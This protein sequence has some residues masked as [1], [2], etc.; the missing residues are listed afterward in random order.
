ML[1]FLGENDPSITSSTARQFVARVLDIPAHEI[2]LNNKQALSLTQ[3]DTLEP[4]LERLR[5]GEPLAYVE[6]SVG[7]YKHEFKI[8]NRALIPRADSEVIVEM[9]CDYLASI[10]S[11]SLLDVGTGSGCLIISLLSELPAA[12]GV[13]VDIKKEALGLAEE[14]AQLIK[15]ASRLQFKQSDCLASLNLRQKFDLILS[16]PPYVMKGEKLGK[17]VAE[18]EPHSAL[19]VTNNDPMQFYCRIMNESLTHLKDSGILVF[20]IG[21]LRQDELA[22]AANLCGYEVIEQRKDMGG[23]VRGIALKPLS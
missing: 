8:D 16:N 13:A 23:V 18:F 9:C 1:S 3:V 20:E 17:S 21:A 5:L 15:V 12:T 7:F 14:N 10:S 4:L 11:P 6:G 19:F 2:S 22:K